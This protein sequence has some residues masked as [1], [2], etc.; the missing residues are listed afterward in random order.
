MKDKNQLVQNW[1]KKAESDL[2]NA[3]IIIK[4]LSD[5]KPLDTVCFHCQQAVEKYLKGFLIF[6]EIDFPKTHNIEVLID[7][8]SEKYPDI[9]QFESAV[10]LSKYAVELRYPDDYYMPDIEETNEAISIA[11][12]IK[13]FVLINISH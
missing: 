8:L 7:L 10:I 11:L 4:S 6:L 3:E 12:S 2:Q 9:E 13:N 5:F 1:F